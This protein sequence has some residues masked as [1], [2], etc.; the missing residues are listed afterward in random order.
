MSINGSPF[1]NGAWLPFVQN[2]A[3]PNALYPY[4]T[5]T[6]TAGPFNSQF[7]NIVNYG[8]DICKVTFVNT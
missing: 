5:L 4:T 6:S 7:N 8:L 3:V 2:I 1:N